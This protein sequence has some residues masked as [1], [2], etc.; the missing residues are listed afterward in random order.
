[1][2]SAG[3]EIM[4]APQQT[5]RRW[6]SR[7]NK[8]V[9]ARLQDKGQDLVK[10]WPLWLCLALALAVRLFLAIRHNPVIEGD[11]ALTGIQ[12]ENILHGQWPIYY[13]GQPY[14]GSLE[15]YIIALFF[16][17]AG[18]SV[19]VLRIAMSCTSLLLVWLT[20]RFGEALASE[21]GLRAGPRRLFLT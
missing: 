11:E 10:A 16:A 19:L 21:A 15:A 6:E 2:L 18:P 12:A 13:Y 8:P 14:M 4:Q 7:T 5:R 17:I 3:S 1:M 20:W 9:L